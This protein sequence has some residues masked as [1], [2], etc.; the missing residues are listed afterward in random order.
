MIDYDNF[1]RCHL[2]DILFRFSRRSKRVKY[3][4]F[5]MS[6]PVQ[7]SASMP[8]DHHKDIFAGS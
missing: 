8:N 1:S 2:T 4:F 5:Q 3:E 7:K 6:D